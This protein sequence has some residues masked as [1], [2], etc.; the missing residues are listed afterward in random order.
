MMQQVLVIRSIIILLVLHSI[1]DVPNLTWN[2]GGGGGGEKR[3]IDN[4]FA[5]SYKYK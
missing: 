5:V 2:G 3:D 1:L 4:C